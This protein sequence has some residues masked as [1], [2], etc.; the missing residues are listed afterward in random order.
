MF[1]HEKIWELGKALNELNWN[2]MCLL[3]YSDHTLGRKQQDVEE[4]ATSNDAIPFTDYVAVSNWHRS[5]SQ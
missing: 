5:S 3:D 1:Q 4:L 2:S